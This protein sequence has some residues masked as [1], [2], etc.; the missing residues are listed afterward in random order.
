LCVVDILVGIPQ[1]ETD[2]V[3]GV[4]ERL[5]ELARRKMTGQQISIANASKKASFSR[6][7]ASMDF[8]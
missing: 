7:Q 6:N 2:V 4:C 3:L 8:G 1:A 5:A